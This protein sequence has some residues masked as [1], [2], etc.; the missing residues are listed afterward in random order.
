MLYARADNG[1]PRGVFALSG[2]LQCQKA[3]S[4]TFCFQLTFIL[5]Q[6]VS[7]QCTWGDPS[8]DCT[9]N[10]PSPPALVSPAAGIYQTVLVDSTHVQL[11]E[12]N[13]GCSVPAQ[14]RINEALCLAMHVQDHQ[15]GCCLVSMPTDAHQSVQCAHRGS[16]T[17]RSAAQTRQCI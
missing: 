13:F 17:L 5:E 3:S 7:L 2:G 9:F 8:L 6:L 14:R 10:N 16:A 4:A 12:S 15:W 1:S 11:L